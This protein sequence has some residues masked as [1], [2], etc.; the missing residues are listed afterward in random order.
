[1]PVPPSSSGRSPGHWR[2]WSK[3]VMVPGLVA[4][5]ASAVRGTFGADAGGLL[6]G[7]AGCEPDP[8]RLQQTGRGG[9]SV[10]TDALVL[11]RIGPRGCG[12]Q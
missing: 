4:H 12:T 7:A 3:G 11:V 10:L 6:H 2:N 5:V 8:C 1:M 9:G